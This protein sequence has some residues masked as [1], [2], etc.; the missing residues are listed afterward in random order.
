M[1][2]R[3]ILS[4][5]M[6]HKTASLL[7]VLE[8]TLSCAIICNA[9][10]VIGSRVSHMQ[11]SS[12]TAEEEIVFIATSSASSNGSLGTTTVEDLAALR[13]IPGVVAAS[14]VNQIPYG[15]S[16]WL[17]SVTLP[18]DES[19]ATWNASVYL[20]DGD[21]LPTLGLRIVEGRGFESSEV[22]DIGATTVFGGSGTIPAALITRSLADQLFPDGDALGSMIQ[23]WENTPIIGIVDELLAPGTA[24][25]PAE[26]QA[27][28][29]LPV[30]TFQGTYAIRTTPERREEVLEAAVAT[31][32]KADPYRLFAT[33][34]TLEQMR[35]D[36][37]SRDRAVVWLLVVVCIALLAVTAFGIVGLASFWVQQRTRQIGVRRA[38]GATRAQILR[39]FQVEN[40]MLTTAGIVL[41]MLLAYGLNQ[42]LMEHYELAR[43][44]LYYLPIGG[45]VLWLLG[46]VAVFAPARRA[47]A[48]PPAIATRSA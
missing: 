10:F 44:P 48:V 20:D 40:F 34:K 47:A 16:N 30:R 13:S 43:L 17:T 4:S 27:S 45:V 14:S 39:Y 35:H 1:E 15:D 33:H 29:I 19:G 28:V 37:H 26:R 32:G 11:A 12:G 6:R 8:I 9:I 23:T 21:L 31:L 3:P 46:Q 5:L 22:L 18:D 42:W 7:I 36:F 2:I 24:R 38:L 25:T 41:G